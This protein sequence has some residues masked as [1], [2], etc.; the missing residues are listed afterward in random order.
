[1]PLTVLQR[2]YGQSNETM[3]RRYQQR[4]AALSVEQAEAIERALLSQEREAKVRKRA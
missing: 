3:T 2:T 4:T 1:M